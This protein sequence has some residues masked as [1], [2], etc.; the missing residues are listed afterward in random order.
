M[1]FNTF[2]GLCRLLHLKFVN[3]GIF[4]LDICKHKS[5]IAKL[6]NITAVGVLFYT[7][8]LIM[9]GL[10][11]HERSTHTNK[12]QQIINCYTDYYYVSMAFHGS[13]VSLLNTLCPYYGDSWKQDLT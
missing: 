4:S 13:L 8:L 5:L 1:L 2:L 12:H 10:T 6:S 11:N 9:S 7:A 3:R